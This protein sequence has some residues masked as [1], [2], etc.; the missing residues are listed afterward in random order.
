MF[1]PCGLLV[2]SEN[3]CNATLPSARRGMS[4]CRPAALQQIP[5]PQKRIGVKPGMVSS[6]CRFSAPSDATQGWSLYQ[7]V[8]VL[9][10]QPRIVKKNATTMQRTTSVI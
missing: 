3:T 7:L 9:V 4:T 5:S 2:G 1:N 10:H 6:L 8:L